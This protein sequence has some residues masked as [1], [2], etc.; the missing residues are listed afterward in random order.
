MRTTILRTFNQGR[1]GDLVNIAHR[2]VL[3]LTNNAYFPNP[4]IALANLEKALEEYRV[5]L[6]NAAGRD[7]ALVAVKNEKRSALR[8][9]LAELAEYVNTVS[10]GNKS[11]LLSSG[12]DCT[13][14]KGEG[15]LRPITSLTV[16]IGPTGQ[17]TTR[18]KR[19]AGARTYVHEY[20][21]DIQMGESAWV[22]RITT[23][24][25][26]TF[27]GLASGVRHWFRVRAIGIGGKTVQSPVESRYIQ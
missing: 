15:P 2:I 13:R 8:A 9:L 22:S 17:A 24:C 26:Y 1:D 10:D 14:E 5:A 3:G 19:I 27:T 4:P 18:T 6:S 21:T 12:F 16:G 20:T 11:I 7:K 23:Y 25:E